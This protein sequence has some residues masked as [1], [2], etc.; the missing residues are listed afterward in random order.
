MTGV[1]ILAAWATYSFVCMT[2][3]FWLLSRA[4]KAIGDMSDLQAAEAAVGIFILG[5]FLLLAPVA[6]INWNH[7][8]EQNANRSG[9]ASAE[10]QLD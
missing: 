8:A 1:L 6:Y 4:Q 7:F 10:R 3:V 5:M 9:Q 2:F